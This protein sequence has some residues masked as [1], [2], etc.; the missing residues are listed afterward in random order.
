MRLSS[1]V[2]VL[3]PPSLLETGNTREGCLGYNEEWQSGFV[4]ATLCPIILCS[5]W[6]GKSRIGVYGVLE[7]PWNAWIW[8]FPL[9][10]ELSQQNDIF[11]T[12]IFTCC[13]GGRRYRSIVLLHNCPVLHAALH[14]ERCQEY[15]GLLD[16]EAKEE[17]GDSLIFDTALEVEYL[18]GLCKAYAVVAKHVFKEFFYKTIPETPSDRAVWLAAEFAQP[19]KR[20]AAHPTVDEAVATLMQVLAGMKP[21]KSQQ[22]LVT[23]LRLVGHRGTQIRLDK[24]TP[25]VSKQDFHIQP[26]VGNGKLCTLMHGRSPITSTRWNC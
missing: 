14:R 19:T 17:P 24:G 11:Y 13:L 3:G 9:T 20:L 2:L 10:Q 18:D 7:N 5:G 15:H 1:G 4:E 23:L 12:R 21:G 6:H 25:T 26:S 22:H 16:Y 8:A